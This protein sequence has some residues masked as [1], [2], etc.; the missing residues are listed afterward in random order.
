VAKKRD[1]FSLGAEAMVVTETCDDDSTADLQLPAAGAQLDRAGYASQYTGKACVYASATIDG[2]GRP[3]QFAAHGYGDGDG[4]ASTAFLP[5][6]KMSTDFVT[7]IDYEF[8]A[9]VAAQPGV[10]TV[11]GVGQIELVGAGGGVYKARL[12]SSG[13]AGTKIESSVP[14]WATLES[15]TTQEEQLF[16]GHNAGMNEDRRLHRLYVAQ[17]NGEAATVASIADGNEILKNGEP[18]GTFAAGELWQGQVD[19]GDV[20]TAAGPIYGISRDGSHARVMVP[21]RLRG[22]EFAVPNSRRSTAHLYVNCLESPCHVTV[23]TSDGVTNTEDI[24]AESFLEIVVT[25][26]IGSDE[27]IVVSSSEPIVMAVSDGGGSIDY[28][29]VPPV[30]TE[31]FGVASTI[32]S[33]ATVGDNA[34]E[35]S[36]SCSE[37]STAT[38]QLPRM[39]GQMETDGYERQYTGKACRLTSTTLVR[40][41]SLCFAHSFS[42]K[43]IIC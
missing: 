1:A 17:A 24:Q 28:T 9:F 40:K 18:L 7:P 4:G 31:V 30:S 19:S 23:S 5:L 37:G 26:A 20:F 3:R 36:E 22:R 39:G 27:A 21:G 10:L 6:D 12:S 33:V 25:G 35:I 2:N 11:D 43:R 41:S 32:L 42:L 14:V 16:Y 13:P 29:P 38:Y 8:I 15:A 34:M